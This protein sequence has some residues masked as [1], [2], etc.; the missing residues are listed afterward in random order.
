MISLILFRTPKAS[1]YRSFTTTSLLLTDDNTSLT[2]RIDQLLKKNP[3][4]TPISASTT[5]A[6][7]INKR[8]DLDKNLNDEKKTMDQY[9]Q[10]NSKNLTED[11][12]KKLTDLSEDSSEFINKVNAKMQTV[13]K[14]D[15]SFM[16]DMFKLDRLH[17]NAEN[18][19]QDSL[20]SVIHESKM[21]QFQDNETDSLKKTIYLALRMKRFADRKKVLEAEKEFVVLEKEY[22]ENKKPSSL[23][24][25][26]ADVSLEQ[27]SH[28]D[29]DD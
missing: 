2:A 10:D 23:I 26:F 15:P 27:P 28:M 13:K 1:K 29:P 11:S 18:K 9:L 22:F 16:L 25:D 14:E 21:E 24:D 7:F 6:K 3:F 20:E 12:I 5:P 4:N 8:K 19:C 17:K